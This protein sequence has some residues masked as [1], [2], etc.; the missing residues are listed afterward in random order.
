M[1]GLFFIFFG[2]IAENFG[3]VQRWEGKEL[4]IHSKDSRTIALTSYIIDKFEELELSIEKAL[5]FRDMIVE[6]SNFLK[7]EVFIHSPF[8]LDSDI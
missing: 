2:D 5:E 3:G 4:Y 6:D 8:H 7:E 1:G